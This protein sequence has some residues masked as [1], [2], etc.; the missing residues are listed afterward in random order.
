MAYL[1]QVL[2]QLLRL[3]FMLLLLLL[4]LFVPSFCPQGVEHTLYIR[5]CCFHSSLLPHFTYLPTVRDSYRSVATHTALRNR[6]LILICS[7]PSICTYPPCHDCHFRATAELFA[8]LDFASVAITV[9]HP[10]SCNHH[11][12]R[13]F[14]LFTA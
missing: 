7:N 12:F 4:L 11:G 14:S 6:T 10:P 13:C 1:Q 5:H 9:P 3:F 8:V 2:R